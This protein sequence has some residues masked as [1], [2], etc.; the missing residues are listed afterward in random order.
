MNSSQSYYDLSRDHEKK[1]KKKMVN[2]GRDIE[3]N[4]HFTVSLNRKPYRMTK[5]EIAL[6]PQLCYAHT[7]F[8]FCIL[9]VRRR[10]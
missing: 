5:F 2:H 10:C 1:N 9:L 7:L 6:L 3:N 4:I 8:F